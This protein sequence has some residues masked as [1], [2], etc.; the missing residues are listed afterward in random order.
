MRRL[1]LVLSILGISGPVA[2]S[3]QY[4]YPYA[5]PPPPR[6]PPAV[7][8]DPFYLNLGLGFGNGSADLGTS[9]L[10]LH[11]WLAQAPGYSQGILGF[12]AEGGVRIMPRLYVGLDLTGIS[13]FGS[14]PNGSQAGATILD[15]DPVLTFFPIGDGLF[16]RGGAG[17]S[18]LS[19]YGPAAGSGTHF[20][21]DVL[22]GAGWA[23]R[24]GG[25]ARLTLGIDWSQQFFGAPDLTGSSFWTGRIGF[26]WY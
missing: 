18:S 6:P 24:L 26:G 1:L 4:A 13:A 3:A 8:E 23:F 17:F 14:A 21:T 10:S 16:L 7:A 20:G 5:Y 22:L 9:S 15:Y 11:D 19:S 25:K 2:A 12:H